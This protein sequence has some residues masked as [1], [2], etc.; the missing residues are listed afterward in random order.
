MKEYNEHN[1]KNRVAQA[2]RMRVEAANA[3][4]LAQ[5]FLLHRAGQIEDRVEQLIDAT[6]DFDTAIKTQVRAKIPKK[7]KK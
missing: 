6:P 1:A 7:G 4:G 5:G 2:E 3:T